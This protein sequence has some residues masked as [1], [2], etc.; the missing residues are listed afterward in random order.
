MDI[1]GTGWANVEF[2]SYHFAEE[3]GDNASIIET[4]HS[5]TLRRGTE[6]PLTQTEQLELRETA[7]KTWE[8]GGYHPIEAKV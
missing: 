1:V 3:Q 2:R 7:K 5:R 6:I 8:D 4:D